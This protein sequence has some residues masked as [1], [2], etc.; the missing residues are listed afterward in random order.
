MKQIN[1]MPKNI[2]DLVAQLETIQ[3]SASQF[4]EL[5]AQAAKLVALLKSMSHWMIC[6]S[7]SKHATII[8]C[9]AT[10]ACIVLEKYG[11]PRIEPY[12]IPAATA[13]LGGMSYSIGKAKNT[14]DNIRK[15][16][17]RFH[18]I[19]RNIFDILNYLPRQDNQRE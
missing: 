6:V 1:F 13:M 3:H 9:L 5:Q 18:I 16:K 12:S 19:C 15:E 2:R 4:P 14:L 17:D 7:A 11:A 8:T 10:L